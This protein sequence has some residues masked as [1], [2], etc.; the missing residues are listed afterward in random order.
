MVEYTQETRLFCILTSWS[1]IHYPAAGLP[2]ITQVYWKECER[3]TWWTVFSVKAF[4]ADAPALHAPAVPHALA[5]TL[6]GAAVVPRE[7][8]ETHALSVHAAP[9]VAAVARA[10]HLAAVV[11]REAPVAHAPAV[12]APAVVVA[13]V[14]AGGHGAVGAFPTRVA[15]TAAGFL[16]VHTVASTAGVQ[17]LRKKGSWLVSKWFP[18]SL[19]SETFSHWK[20][21]ERT[22]LHRLTWNAASPATSLRTLA[23]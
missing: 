12:H 1:G 6:L 4:V 17:A 18:A 10:R 14:G 15:H 16:L 8:R 9:L 21:F 19:Y 11:P 13:L 5:W 3:P 2:V 20:R 22:P 23:L 7:V